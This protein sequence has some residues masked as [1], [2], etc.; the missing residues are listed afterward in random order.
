MDNLLSSLY[1][2]TISFDFYSDVANDANISVRQGYIVVIEKD[3]VYTGVIT[4]YYT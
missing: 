2:S 3:D 4:A 1:R